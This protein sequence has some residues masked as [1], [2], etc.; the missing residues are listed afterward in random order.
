MIMKSPHPSGLF[1]CHFNGKA[2][3]VAVLAQE[4]RLRGI[5]PW[6]DKEGGFGFADNCQ[7]EAR[8]VI[9][10]AEETFG[11]LL[12]ASPEVFSRDFIRYVELP[13]AVQRKE[14]DPDYL[15]SV[16]TRG[17]SRADLGKQSIAEL[18]TDLNKWHGRNIEEK[19]AEGIN[20]LPLRP[21]LQSMANDILQARVKMV[22][23]ADT[24][25]V[26]IN[27]CTRECLPSSPDDLFFVDATRVVAEGT[28][29]GWRRVL[30]GL[31]DV[32]KAIRAIQ[33][34]PVIRV[35]GSK[36]L[37]AAF[38]VGRLFTPPTVSELR[39][40]QN[41][42]EWSTQCGGLEIPSPL[43]FTHEDESVSS[44]HLFVELSVNRD[45]RPAVRQWVRD[46][47]VQPTAYLRF[48]WPPEATSQGLNEAQAC[49]IARQIRNEVQLMVDQRRVEKVHIFA[50][51]PQ[52]LLAILGHHMNAMV[53]IQLY[54]YDGQSY[55]PSLTVSSSDFL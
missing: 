38:L 14:R 20:H 2:A 11:L 3:E 49:A 5:V 16:L 1:L 32:K 33:A 22:L 41:D 44:R 55:R 15:F 30:D 54:E 9:G 27:L 48:T 50:A 7:T 40:Q 10:D 39:I 13:T 12:Y 28:P 37:S 4:L 6:V 8:R 19:D 52:G 42:A 21:Q 26:G 34:R 51:A 29:D 47:G 17:L 46:S 43:R 24:P 31:K 35:R 45:V 36:H 18:G 25:V 23:N 53:A